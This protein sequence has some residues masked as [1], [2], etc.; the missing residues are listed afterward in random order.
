MPIERI[1]PGVMTRQSVNEPLYTGIKVDAMI[2]LG[3]GN[4]N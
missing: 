2:P 1:A 4:V 3:K